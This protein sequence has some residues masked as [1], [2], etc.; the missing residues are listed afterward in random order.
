LFAYDLYQHVKENTLNSSKKV[1]ALLKSKNHKYDKKKMKQK[2]MRHHSK[3]SEALENLEAAGAETLKDISK[4]LGDTPKQSAGTEFETKKQRSKDD[5][6]SDKEAVSKKSSLFG[7]KRKAEDHSPNRSSSSKNKHKIK[8]DEEEDSIDDFVPPKKMFKK[9]SK[10]SKGESQSSG[11]KKEGTHHKSGE[12]KSKKV[13]S[14]KDSKNRD[15]VRHHYKH[16]KHRHSSDS[17]KRDS[18]PKSNHKLDSEKHYAEKHNESH[19]IEKSSSH[20]SLKESFSSE[21]SIIKHSK[22]L[23]EKKPKPQIKRGNSLLTTLKNAAGSMKSRIQQINKQQQKLNSFHAETKQKPGP[24]DIHG[25][26][27]APG[28]HSQSANRDNGLVVEKPEKKKCLL[29]ND[30]SADREGGPKL[31][32]G[33]VL[34]TDAIKLGEFKKEETGSDDDYE[35][36]ISTNILKPKTE[37][38]SSSGGEQKSKENEGKDGKVTPTKSSKDSENEAEKESEVEVDRKL[39]PS[40]G[41]NREK[42]MP[43]LS[44]WIK[45]FGGPAKPAGAPSAQIKK[46]DP[47][48]KNKFKV[49]GRGVGESH[50]VPGSHEPNVQKNISKASPIHKPN[51]KPLSEAPWNNISVNSNPP[52][53][54]M[55]EQPAEEVPT[56][57]LSHHPSKKHRHRKMSTSSMS[58]QSESGSPHCFN[59]PDAAGVIGGGVVNPPRWVDEQWTQSHSQSQSPSASSHVSSQSPANS[60]FS[61]AINSPPHTPQ[62]P[63]RPLGTIRAGFYQDITSQ[64]S[65]PEKL[66]ESH[67]N[68]NSNVASPSTPPTP[69]NTSNSSRR[70]EVSSNSNNGKPG[71]GNYPT[72]VYAPRYAASTPSPNVGPA[73][74]LQSPSPGGMGS[75]VDSPGNPNSPHSPNVNVNPITSVATDYRNPSSYS[76]QQSSQQQQQQQQS[77]TGSTGQSSQPTPAAHQQQSTAHRGSASILNPHNAHSSSPS[78]AP[79][80]PPV[81]HYGHPSAMNPSHSS[82]PGHGGPQ[83]AQAHQPAMAHINQVQAHSQMNHQQHYDRYSSHNLAHHQITS[84]ASVSS[85]S[86]PNSASVSSSYSQ[87]L[88]VAHSQRPS[89]AQPSPYPSNPYASNPRSINIPP[90]IYNN[91]IST[92][93]AMNRF[94]KPTVSGGE[95]T[96]TANA[97]ISSVGSNEGITSVSY[98]R[99][100]RSSRSNAAAAAE[101]ELPRSSSANLEG[102]FG[103]GDLNGFQWP[104]NLASLS[105]I[106]NSIP[107]SMNAV[108]MANAYRQYDQAMAESMSKYQRQEAAGYTNL[109]ASAAASLS[110]HSS[111]KSSSNM[112]HPPAAHSH[113]LGDKGSESANDAPVVTSRRQSSKN[114][115]SKSSRYG[116]KVSQL[117]ICSTVPYNLFITRILFLFLDRR[118]LPNPAHSPWS[119]EVRLTF[120]P[121]PLRT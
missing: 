119:P 51:H 106:V 19:H 37:D 92:D 31:S 79:Y 5:D 97:S 71:Y 101:S 70:G 9:S 75:G 7:H 39:E 42:C 1:A 102:K 54:K 110:G 56:N 108:G 10:H 86:I 23:E 41:F 4:W 48:T 22:S 17:G 27:S 114:S 11:S 6:E 100:S 104:H 93:P 116:D 53:M 29:L 8:F 26:K 34:S 81:G 38:T 90:N 107:N 28:E 80:P 3:N 67:S 73:S 89:T 58:S 30:N 83:P 95:L 85:S 118:H 12:P 94:Y 109:S 44:A 35:S 2:L 88:T 115:E 103:H 18:P 33:S 62:T 55:T 32:L 57:N 60:P 105:Q 46:P 111:G 68:S 20:K 64:H 76:S 16:H 61:P 78:I 91:P 14:E 69:T 98:S 82:D 65:S 72:P 52:P 120:H 21:K 117:F 36:S 40:K 47:E 74:N 25:S 50:S 15:K 49:M 45:A 99:S 87:N 63:P 77:S 43:N 113:S 121:S 96:L 59:N 24:G 66:N 13:P 84:Q 112:S